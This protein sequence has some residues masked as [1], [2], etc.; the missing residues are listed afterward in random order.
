MDTQTGS[1]ST[2]L[3][4]QIQAFQREFLPKV[5]QE[6]VATLQ[7]TTADLGRSGIAERAL[8]VGDR[9]PNFSLPNVRGEQV[10]L[11]DLLG[12]GPAVVTFYRG[13]W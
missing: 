1:L 4:E 5:P 3:L 13:G 7:N 6:I 12:R 2:E 11:S 8:R 10:T 9:A